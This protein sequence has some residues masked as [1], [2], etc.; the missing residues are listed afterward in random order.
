[1]AYAITNE[2]RL[3]FGHE[4]HFQYSAAS[5][6]AIEQ[7]HIETQWRLITFEDNVNNNFDNLLQKMDAA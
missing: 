6:C 2:E 3:Q 5:L 1:V 7:A 4:L